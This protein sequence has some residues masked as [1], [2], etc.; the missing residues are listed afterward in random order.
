M[1]KYKITTN[2]KTK[3]IE[4]DEVE[5]VEGILLDEKLVNEFEKLMN[6]PIEKVEIDGIVFSEIYMYY[7]PDEEVNFESY[8]YQFKD[9]DFEKKTKHY[10]MELCDFVIEHY[11]D[12]ISEKITKQ[13][14]NRLK[15]FF[16]K[17]KKL[18]PPKTSFKK[19]LEMLYNQA[20]L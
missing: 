7:M 6:T 5:K 12:K 17:N 11:L 13:M 1:P 10:G 18:F 16:E 14:H 3:I 8:N 2:N 19:A 4:A 20:T 15:K 9:K